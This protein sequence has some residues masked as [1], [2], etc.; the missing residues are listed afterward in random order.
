MK[1][2]KKKKKKLIGMGVL[3]GTPFKALGGAM[4]TK[5]ATK[6]FEKKAEEQMERWNKEKEH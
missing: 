6:M 4:L 3:V 1:K 2:E 5:E